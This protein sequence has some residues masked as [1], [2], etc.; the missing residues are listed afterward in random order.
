MIRN[1][2]DIYGSRADKKS[3]EEV[4]CSLNYSDV[5]PYESQA[6]Y[7]PASLLS[8]MVTAT[9]ASPEDGGGIGT[10]GRQYIDPWDLENY[11]YLQR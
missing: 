4:Y 5:N 2:Y 11:A 3:L 6:E 8:S 1:P 9:R 10:V 7:I